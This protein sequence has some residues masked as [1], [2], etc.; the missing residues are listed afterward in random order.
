VTVVTER[1]LHPRGTTAATASSALRTRR[2][3]D[4]DRHMLFQQRPK[5]FQTSHALTDARDAAG[6]V[7]HDDLFPHREPFDTSNVLP[8]QSAR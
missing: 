4:I 5:T 1:T 6:C 8:Q 7:S 2:G 3:P